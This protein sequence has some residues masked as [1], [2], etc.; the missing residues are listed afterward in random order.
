[1]SVEAG[2]DALIT[3][4]HDKSGKS[5]SQA[6]LFYFIC[7]QEGVRKWIYLY[8]LCRFAKLGKAARVSPNGGSRSL[9]TGLYKLLECNV[10]QNSFTCAQKFVHGLIPICKNNLNLAMCSFSSGLNLVPSSRSLCCHACYL[11]VLRCFFFVFFFC[12][13]VLREANFLVA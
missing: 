2:I 8:Q 9:P 13:F 4:S 1:M 10:H 6:D 5:C 7:E 11:S 12:S 3:V